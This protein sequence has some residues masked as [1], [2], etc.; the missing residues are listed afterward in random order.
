M[1]KWR[2]MGIQFMLVTQEE[3]STARFLDEHDLNIRVLL[4]TTGE[5]AAA[6]GVLAIPHTFWI[7][8]SGIVRYAG[9]GWRKENLK[10]FE[11]LAADLSR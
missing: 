5:V 7:D 4:D 1:P 10:T 8:K 2:E 6:Y 9:V 3:G 11:E